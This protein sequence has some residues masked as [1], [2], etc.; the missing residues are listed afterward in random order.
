MCEIEFDG[1]PVVGFRQQ[2][3]KARKTH[4]CD[5]CGSTIKPGDAYLYASW[6][7]DRKPD[8]EKQCA[9]CADDNREF[10]KAHG[11]CLF[12]DAFYTYL[13]ECVFDPYAGEDEDEDAKRWR[14]ML[15][16]LKAR[17]AGARAA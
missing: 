12:A 4:V 7:A 10:S 11:V 3:R 14:P 16:R 6:I 17:M 15:E 5:C 1:D 2:T 13:N 9:A 8:W